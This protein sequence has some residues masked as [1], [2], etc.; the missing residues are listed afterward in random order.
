LFFVDKKSM[1]GMQMANQ[2]LDQ[3]RPT[4]F[5][6]RQHTPGR[7]ITRVQDQG[8]ALHSLITTAAVVYDET[9]RD[10]DAHVD[11]GGRA[12]GHQRYVEERDA[13]LL[14]IFD[15]AMHAL[16]KNAAFSLMNQSPTEIIRE[17]YI[18]DPE[19]R[20]SFFQTLTGR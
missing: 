16:V 10:L 20:K 8:E 19:P 13:S 1:E 2:S 3:R 15:G 6:Y 7:V 4:E 5:M 14:S 17:I 18:H 12:A 9:W 11:K